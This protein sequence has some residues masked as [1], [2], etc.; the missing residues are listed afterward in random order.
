MTLVQDGFQ[1]LLEGAAI[2]EAF[3]EPVMKTFLACFAHPCA[4]HGTID[5]RAV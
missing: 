4:L 3:G 1:N 2:L 5:E